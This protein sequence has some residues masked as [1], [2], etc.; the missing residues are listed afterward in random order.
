MSTLD[1]VSLF[2]MTKVLYICYVPGNTTSKTIH[3]TKSTQH[4]TLNWKRPVMQAVAWT[5]ALDALYAGHV[6]R[7]LHLYFQIP[8]RRTEP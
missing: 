8:G 7:R 3:A 5:P 2:G 4:W 6:A 1:S